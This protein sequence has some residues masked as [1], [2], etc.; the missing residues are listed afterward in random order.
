MINDFEEKIKSYWAHT[1]AVVIVKEIKRR[2][3]LPKWE[4]CP[5]DYIYVG[6]QRGKNKDKVTVVQHG[7]EGIFG[8]NC[9]VEKLSEK[10][11]FSIGARPLSKNLVCIKC[12]EFSTWVDSRICHDCTERGKRVE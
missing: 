1:P 11:M 12:G 10:D 5:K 7:F 3:E 6:V 4:D 8:L 2:T 9:K